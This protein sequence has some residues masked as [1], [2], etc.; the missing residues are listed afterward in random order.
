MLTGDRE[1]GWGALWKAELHSDSMIE[2]LRRESN[3]FQGITGCN[4][5]RVAEYFMAVKTPKSKAVLTELFNSGGRYQKLIGA[6][7]LLAQDSYPEQIDGNSYIGR[8]LREDRGGRYSIEIKIVMIALAKSKRADAVPEII[9]Y[10]LTEHPFKEYACEALAE[11]KPPEA[12]PV[13]HQC[14]LNPDFISHKS[15]FRALIALGEKSAVPEA[16]QM[17]PAMKKNNAEGIVK[18]LQD[19]TG[20]K[21]GVNKAEWENWWKEEGNRWQIPARFKNYEYLEKANQRRL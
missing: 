18:N 21:Y 16:I 15:A 7:G 17:L 11:I 4:I 1:E 2:P 19:M 14:L 9:N 6:A 8:V 10:L 3:N 13:L 20:R 12:I 5:E